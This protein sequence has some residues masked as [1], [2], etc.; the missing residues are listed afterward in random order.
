MQSSTIYY[1]IDDPRD[2]VRKLLVLLCV[3][4]V[5]FDQL[6]NYCVDKRQLKEC[7]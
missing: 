1:I 6:F 7:G 4:I 3:V 5:S 2:L